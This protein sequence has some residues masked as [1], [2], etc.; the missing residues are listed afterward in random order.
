MKARVFRGTERNIVR[1]AAAL[2]RGELVAVPTET[3]YGLAGDALNL[4]AVEKIFTAKG[5]PANDPLIIHIHALSQLKELAEV[6]A[7][8]L[9]VAHAFWPGPLT[10]VL[11]KKSSVPDAVTS[12]RPSVAVRMP[13]HPLFRK[14]LRACRLPLAAPSANLFGYVSPTTAEHV[15]TGLGRKILYILDGG[16]CAIG[17]ESTILDLRD[18]AHPAIL[19]PGAVEHTQIEHVLGVSVRGPRGEKTAASKAAVAPGMLARHYSPRTPIRL[20]DSLPKPSATANSGE[21]FVYFSR[22]AFSSAQKRPKNIFWLSQRGSLKEAA[23]ALFATL[24]ELDA[25]GWKLLHA[26]RAPGDSALA[27]AINDRLTRAA[28]KR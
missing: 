5:R 14:L 20:V 23:K 18:P 22:P 8:A 9:K 13:S 4:A 17:V 12:G 10:L 2:V 27:L 24:R 19:R 21:A 3:V 1:L 11:P 7:A 25:G 28:A 26:E 16:A 6:N 15:R